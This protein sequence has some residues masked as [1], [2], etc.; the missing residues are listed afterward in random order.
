MNPELGGVCQAIRTL[1]KGLEDLNVQNE[2]VCLDVPGVEFIKADHFP[3][4]AIGPAAGPW[5]YNSAL[6]PWL[7]TNVSRFNVI[8]LHGLW[9]YPNYAI[10]KALL[11]YQKKRTSGSVQKYL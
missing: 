11:K 3:V 8:I 10:R 2:V 7:F 5:A 4:H 6:S 1:I 9:L